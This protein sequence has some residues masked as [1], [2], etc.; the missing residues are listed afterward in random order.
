MAI[1]DAAKARI[2]DKAHRRPTVRPVEFARTP[3]SV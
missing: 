2:K 3:R 1:T